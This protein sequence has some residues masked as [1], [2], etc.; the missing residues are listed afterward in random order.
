VDKSADQATVDR[1]WAERLKLARREQISVPLEDINWAREV[2]SDAERRIRADAASLN[3]DTAD[4]VVHKLNQYCGGDATV[5]PHCQP[6]D[7]DR[8]L[9]DYPPDV[10]I[11]DMEAFRASI[12]VGEVPEEFPAARRVVEKYVRQPLDPWNLPIRW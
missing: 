1:H 9:A 10:E 3:F 2:L 12:V 8:N 11:P 4:A 5:G 6:L 7:D